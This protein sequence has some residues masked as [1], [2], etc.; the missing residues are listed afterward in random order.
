MASTAR[1]FREAFPNVRI[2]MDDPVML[3]RPGEWEPAMREFLEVYRKEFGEPMGFVRLE[4][5]SFPVREWLPRYIA[6]EKFLRSVGVPFGELITGDASDASDAIWVQK[7]EERYV[8]WESEGRSAPG[9]VV[10]QSWMPRPTRILPENDP[11]TLTHLLNGY[12]RDRTRLTLTRD[13]GVLR[14][15]LVDASGAPVAGGHVEVTAIAGFE[16]QSMVHRVI[17]CP[18]PA[19]A[20]FVEIGLRI[21]VEGSPVGKAH[22]TMGATKYEEKEGD[23]GRV[24][25][26]AEGLK[27]WG[28]KGTAEV[29]PSHDA[30]MAGVKIDAEAGRTLL[31]NSKL[32]P[33]TGGREA[34]FT[35]DVQVQ[36]DTE[37]GY[38]AM[39]FFD[40]SKKV[41][42]RMQEPLVTEISSGVRE[43]V[44]DA[45]GNFELGL[46]GSEL[47]GAREYRFRYGGDL[48]RRCALATVPGAK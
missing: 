39:F 29:S 44:T 6:A 19:D 43:L 12:F 36:A 27:G 32:L 20:R 35:F 22:L 8:T 48:G 24:F 3:Y 18:V 45:N 38:L 2:G 31:L 30:G 14:G 4:C 37:T 28:R 41:V 13:A 25:D 15:R 47:R 16:E 1:Q 33:V 17:R 7:A 5:A 9:Q 26:F 46:T 23:G 42:H 10:F 34:M 40:S 11:D 21:G